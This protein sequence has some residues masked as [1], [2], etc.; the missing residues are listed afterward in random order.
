MPH[1]N[2]AMAPTI[3]QPQRLPATVFYLALAAIV[4][5][6]A[7]G[8]K[9]DATGAAGQP[10]TPEVGVVTVQTSDIALI[11]ELPGRLEA[12]RVAQ[13]RARAAGILQKRV[14]TEGSDVKAG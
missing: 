9:D 3:R 4:T 13:V 11:T 6:G 5:L 2:N 12:S 10:R 7:C 1:L 14:F 8:K